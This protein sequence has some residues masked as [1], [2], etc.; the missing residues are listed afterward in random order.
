ML[1]PIT[2]PRR[3]A[4]GSYID[5]VVADRA[6]EEGVGLHDDVGAEHGVRAQVRARFDPAAVADHDRLVDARLGAQL[7]V[8]ADPPTVA[9]LESVDLHAHAAVEHVGVRPAVGLERADVLP[10]PFGD[11]TVQRVAMVEERGKHVAGEVD[12]FT[13]GD[14][15]EHR[16]LEH[17]DAGVDGVGE[18]LAPRRLLEEPLDAA[19]GAGDHDAE[20]EGILDVLERDRRRRVRVAV[21]LHERGE[22]DVGEYVAGDHEEGVV[23]L[24]GRVAH[25]TGGAERRI[26]GRVPHGHTEIGPVAEVVADLVGQERDGDHDVVEAVL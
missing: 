15:V 17:V 16:G 4:P 5:V 2:Q 13:V 14:E 21:R 24:V 7:D 10:V 6:L 22:I 3:L 11:V 26:L 19:V 12:D 8:G 18:H 9:E 25:R 23:E 20:L 1:R